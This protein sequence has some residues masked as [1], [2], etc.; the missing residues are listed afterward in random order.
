MYGA[1]KKSEPSSSELRKCLSLAFGK[2]YYTAARMSKP[3][4]QL[5]RN[6]PSRV[7]DYNFHLNV[8]TILNTKKT[9]QFYC[10]FKI[11]LLPSIQ[12]IIVVV[13]QEKSY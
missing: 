10:V 2:Q 7:G 13:Y 8:I 4:P 5:R 12:Q 6:K 9:C 3:R 1:L 11:N